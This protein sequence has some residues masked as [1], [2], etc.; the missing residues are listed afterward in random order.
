MSLHDLQI[1]KKSFGNL[2]VNAVEKSSVVFVI[3]DSA[4]ETGEGVV[5]AA[6]AQFHP[7]RM[8]IQRTSYVQSE[9]QID[10]AVA[11]AAAAQGFIVFTL[12]SS[13]TT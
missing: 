9:Q 13:G 10:Q 6:A 4:G 11:Q 12:G 2:E 8:N 1:S 7:L 3:S 5:R